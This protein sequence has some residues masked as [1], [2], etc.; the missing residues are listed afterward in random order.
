MTFIRVVILLVAVFLTGLSVWKLEGFRAGLEISHA[1]V[2]DTPV[3]VYSSP[4]A[5]PAPAVVI[6]HGFAGSRQLMEAFALTLAHAGYVAV[7][8]DFEGHGRNPTPMSGDVTAIEGTTQLLMSETER[9]TDFA[10][11]LEQVDGRVALLGHSMASDIVV[12]QTIADPRIAATVAISLFSQAVSEDAP[13]RLIAVNGEWEAMLREEA[14]RVVQLVDADATEGV[15]VSVGDVTRRAVF[16]PSV[17]HVGVLYAP[18]SLQESKDWLDLAF[19]RQ[20]NGLLATTG[21]W[22]A[23]L[24]VSLLALSW[25]LMTLVPHGAAPEKIA[26][27]DYLTALSAAT[28]LT[29]LVLVPVELNILPVLVAD[30]LGLHL[31]V[32]GMIVLAVLRWRGMALPID[33][34]AIALLLCTFGIAVFGLALDRYIAS[35]MPHAARLPIIAALSLGAVT[36]MIA[37]AALTEAGQAPLWRRVATKLGFLL[38]LGIAVALDFEGLFF[39]LIIL[40]VIVLY[41]LIF[42]SIGGWAGRRSGSVFGVGLGLGIILA[43]S[44]GV[45]FPLFDAG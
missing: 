27:R 43:W 1:R 44:L 45:T 36:C 32:F 16:A 37:D 3:T 40:P 6:A 21:G 19:D 20:S 17:E 10:L 35:F 42:G 9:I 2:G 18:A 33:G 34:W 38:S 4:E 13:R 8:F 11:E 30:Y 25:P 22:I 31:L 41:F 7:S 39:L 29:P 26:R 5:P 24:L 28:L 15:T 12:R 23:L 14:R